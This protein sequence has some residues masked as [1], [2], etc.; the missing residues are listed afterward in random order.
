MVEFSVCRYY[1]NTFLCYWC[2]ENICTFSTCFFYDDFY[3]SNIPELHPRFGH[4][5]DFS[6][7]KKIITPEIT[8]T[9][10]S[11]SEII[12]FE[13]C[14]YFSIFCKIFDTTETAVCLLDFLK[15]RNGNFLT[16]AKCTLSLFCP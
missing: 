7:S 12:E 15:R 16:I 13:K 3:C 1:S 4:D 6:L 14:I 9:T 10:L 5:I 2:S 11:Q 8:N